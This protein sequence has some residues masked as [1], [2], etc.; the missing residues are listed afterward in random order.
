MKLFFIS[1]D[2]VPSSNSQIIKARFEIASHE[3]E[4]KNSILKISFGGIL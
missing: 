4:Y 3:I 2:P 1:D